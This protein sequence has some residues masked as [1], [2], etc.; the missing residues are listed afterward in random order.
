M[1]FVIHM[2]PL[3]PPVAGNSRSTG[4]KLPP[5]SVLSKVRTNRCIQ[6]K[7]MFAAIASD[8]YKANQMGIGIGPQMRQAKP[9][10]RAEWFGPNRS[11]EVIQGSQVGEWINLNVNH[12]CPH[13]R[14]IW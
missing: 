5:D 14:R 11:P 7:R 8:I 13:V 3:R 1:G 4:H 6:N 2:Q 12:T 9:Q 10:V